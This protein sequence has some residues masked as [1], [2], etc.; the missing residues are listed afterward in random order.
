MVA[1]PRLTRILFVP[2]TGH[3]VDVA[4]VRA[5]ARVR[6]ADLAVRVEPRRPVA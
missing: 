1:H 2:H 5:V 3:G 4:G 6:D